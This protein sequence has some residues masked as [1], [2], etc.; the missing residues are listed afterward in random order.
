MRLDMA[1]F[2]DGVDPVQATMEANE[3]IA[4]AALTDDVIVML[5]DAI[6]IEFVRYVVEFDGDP[7]YL[8]S[9]ETPS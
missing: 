5:P 7:E 1:G 9:G 3:P 4:V 6:P 2:L 8:R